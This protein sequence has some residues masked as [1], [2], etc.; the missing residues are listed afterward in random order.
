MKIVFCFHCDCHI[1]EP[2][3]EHRHNHKKHKKHVARDRNLNSRFI[4]HNTETSM[5]KYNL[6][7]TPGVGKTRDVI[8]QQADGTEKVLATG[9]P[10]E[11]TNVDVDFQ[12]DEQVEWFTRVTNADGTSKQDSQHATFTANDQTPAP[13]ATADTGLTDKFVSHSPNQ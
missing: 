12:D 5:N 1:E 8:Q 10:I 4:S 13:A 9:L 6:G 7:W 11:Q 3:Q 2:E